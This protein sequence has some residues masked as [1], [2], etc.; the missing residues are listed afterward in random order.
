M[1]K[2]LHRIRPAAILLRAACG[3]LIDRILEKLMNRRLLVIMGLAALL[4]M[5]LLAGCQPVM[6]PPVAPSQDAGALTVDAL[7]NATYSGI[8]DDPVTLTDGRYEDEPFV[9]GDAAR[10]TVTYEDGAE[11]F[12]DL[13]GDGVEDAVVFLVENSGGTGN[14]VYVAAQLNRD[15]QPLDAGAVWIE[16]R[17]QVSPFQ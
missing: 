2:T 12:A 7:R 5:L 4:A 13:D 15:G 8:Y 1:S 16:D 14:F 11:R 9:A 10:P 17:I 6:A 3:A